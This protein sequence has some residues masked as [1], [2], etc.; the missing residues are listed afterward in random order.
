ME[1]NR[2]GLYRNNAQSAWRHPQLRQPTLADRLSSALTL[3][4]RPL[5]GRPHPTAIQTRT[6]SIEPAA[7]PD[8]FSLRDAIRLLGLPSIVGAKTPLEELR[9]LVQFAVTVE[10]GLMVQYL[11]AFYAAKEADDLRS[12]AI[13]EMGHFLTVLNLLVALDAPIHLGRYDGN[14]DRNFDPFPFK[15]EKVSAEVIAKF[16]ACERPDDK[17][18]DPEEWALLPEILDVAR[19]SAGVTPA[20]VGLLYA[21]IYW[22]LRPS[23]DP[24]PDE[25]WPDF[26]I[27]EVI[28]E[29]PK[30]W[31]VKPFPMRNPVGREG[32][33]P[34]QNHLTTVLVGSAVSREQALRGVAEL[35]SQGEGF[36]AAKDA[37][38]DRFVALYVTLKREPDPTRQVPKDPWYQGSPGP[39]GEAADE[40]SSEPARLVAIALD[41]LYEFLLLSIAIFFDHSDTE[42][43]DAR[44]VLTAAAI[45]G[46]KRCIGTLARRLVDM[47]RHAGTPDGRKAAPCFKLPGASPADAA[48]RKLRLLEIADLCAKTGQDIAAHPAVPLIVK[49]AAK[50]AFREFK[51]HKENIEQLFGPM[52]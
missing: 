4:F 41:Q 24:L 37:H 27:D 42:N 11:Y 46:M 18:V 44:T 48:G 14:L 22:L 13:E 31:H 23:D 8:T 49:V 15:L 33:E 40:I 16:A 26:P 20:R 10:H 21:K 38:F 19:K 17:H 47:D 43:P 50:D 5:S 28:K 6:F 35:T 1:E 45:G 2:P 34:W 32:G 25:P 29:C 36:G 39:Q 52:A 12:I 30:D 9:G 7:T 51:K 3:D